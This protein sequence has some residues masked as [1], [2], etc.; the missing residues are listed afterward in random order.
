M[1]KNKSEYDPV[2]IP[3]HYNAGPGPEAIDLIRMVIEG[4]ID[5]NKPITMEVVWAAC[6]Q[7]QTVKYMLRH[8]RKGKPQQDME[9]AAWYLDESISARFPESEH[10][11]EHRRNNRPSLIVD[12]PCLDIEGINETP[13]KTDLP[14]WGYSSDKN[15]R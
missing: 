3:E 8:N 9:K 13:I 10:G 14:N 2:K 1:L 4:S 7:Y 15:D 11:K 5:W 6:M 12:N